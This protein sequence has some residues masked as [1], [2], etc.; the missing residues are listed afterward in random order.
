MRNAGSG[1]APAYEFRRQ[2][3]I[4]CMASIRLH[5]RSGFNRRVWQ[6]RTDPGPLT[7]Q[8]SP[9]YSSTVLPLAHVYGNTKV[10]CESNVVLLPAAGWGSA[11]QAAPHRAGACTRV[12]GLAAHL[13]GSIAA[14]K[15]LRTSRFHVA[16]MWQNPCMSCPSAGSNYTPGSLQG[17]SSSWLRPAW[18]A[19]CRITGIKTSILYCSTCIAL[20]Q[21]LYYSGCVHHQQNC[22]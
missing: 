12:A 9:M 10:G 16:K 1:Q 13:R 2:F 3:K 15:P 18:V 6:E 19:R 11:C 5:A 14:W 22:L 17:A 8:R 21:A 20:H 7:F 4:L